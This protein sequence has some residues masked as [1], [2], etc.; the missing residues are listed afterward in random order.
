MF[1]QLFPIIAT[2][3]VG[4]ALGFYQEQLGGTVGYEFAGAD[5]EA[6][7]VGM[8]IGTSHFGIGLEPAGIAAE[9]I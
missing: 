7:Y 8:E 1:T 2:A 9:S 5:G 4:R 6:A 3:D